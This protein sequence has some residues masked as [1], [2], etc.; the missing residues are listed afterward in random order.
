MALTNKKIFFYGPVGGKNGK[1]VGGGESGNKKTIFILKK[2]GF[3]LF[4][5]EKPYPIKVP[6]FNFFVYFIQLFFVYLKFFFKIFF[7]KAL[8]KDKIYFHL[9]GFYG[10][11]IY[12]EWLYIKT[13]SFLNIKCIYEIRAGGAI[14][15]YLNSNF[16][17]KF[18]F[19]SILINS[20]KILCQGFE[21]IGFVKSVANIDAVYYPNFILDQFVYSYNSLD[22]NNSS[23]IQMVYFGRI[24]P[25]K[26]VDFILDICNNISNNDFICEII[27][28]GTPDY[29]QY[30]NNRIQIL[31]LEHKV[32]ILPPKN[33]QELFE[34]LPNKHFFLFP[35]IEKREGHS[36]SLT[37]AMNFG[38]VPISSYAGFNPSIIQDSNLLINEY[39]PVNYANKIISIWDSKMW[40]MYSFQCSNIVK[41]NY[42]ES[43]IKSTLYSLY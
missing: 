40:E 38:V 36:N 11:L 37:E 20:T 41:N 2:L 32:F 14:E 28:E 9:S 35:S 19:K 21:Y 5:I 33:S 15:I 30:L 22:R 7:N 17:Y 43:V 3:Q 13:C 16:I 6:F 42:T 4:L 25:S 10:H 8:T 39:N 27:G 29:V 34:I 26:N 12:I 1:I 31:G 23:I 24:A 18:F